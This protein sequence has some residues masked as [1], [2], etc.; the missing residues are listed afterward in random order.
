MSWTHDSPRL[1]QRRQ[2]NS[3]R[4]QKAQKVRRMQSPIIQAPPFLRE[5][6]SAGTATAGCKSG[7]TGME[8]KL[9][10]HFKVIE[11]ADPAADCFPEWIATA[12]WMEKK[13]GLVRT[14]NSTY[15]LC[16]IF[17]LEIIA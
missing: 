4:I 11:D 8:M 7:V 12:L 9:R 2:G 13:I 17:Y 1:R 16:G 6:A 15:I 3:P 5:L 14:Q 10:L